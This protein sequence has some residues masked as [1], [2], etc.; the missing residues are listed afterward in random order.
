LGSALSQ[1]APGLL[2]LRA[3]LGACSASA[4]AP[5]PES[6]AWR[7]PRFTTGLWCAEQRPRWRRCCVPGKPV[8]LHSSSAAHG[9]VQHAGSYSMRGS[10]VDS[11]DSTRRTDAPACPAAPSKLTCS[12][13]NS[14]VP[15]FGPRSI[16]PPA[17]RTPTQAA[18][19]SA[20]TDTVSTDIV[21][22]NAGQRGAMDSA[23]VSPRHLAARPGAPLRP[24]DAASR[25][26][27][28]ATADAD[29]KRP[30]RASHRPRGCATPPVAPLLPSPLTMHSVFRQTPFETPLWRLRPVRY[31]TRRQSTQRSLATFVAFAGAGGCDTG[32]GV[33]RVDEAAHLNPICL[34]KLS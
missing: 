11:H 3:S 18:T 25:H 13:A 15:H 20:S 27:P 29:S 2:T 31:A 8:A 19:A 22:T 10:A 24:V 9:D 21:S 12:R 28:V 30:V 33:P 16:A 32:D 1:Q 4:R 23:D 17:F 7:T 34:K 14:C 5:C 26:R 6:A